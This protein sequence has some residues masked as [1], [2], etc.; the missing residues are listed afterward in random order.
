MI[1][2]IVAIVFLTGASCVMIGA[3]TLNQ[4]NPSYNSALAVPIYN[5]IGIILALIGLV[6]AVVTYQKNRDMKLAKFTMMVGI[7]CV[8]VLVLLFPLSNTG[9][10]SVIR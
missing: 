3:I 4:I 7:V 6:V 1:G 5:V 8:I 10:L 2:V 9:S